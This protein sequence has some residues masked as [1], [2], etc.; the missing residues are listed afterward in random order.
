[1]KKEVF[2]NVINTLP[3]ILKNLSSYVKNRL[4]KD[5]QELLENSNGTI[6]VLI[7]LFA[8][9]AIDKYFETLENK[10][11]LQHGSLNYFKA[12]LAQVSLSLAKL[13]YDEKEMI[14]LHIK[15]IL[16]K[17]N[18]D[19]D[20]HKI[21][22]DLL[23]IFTPQYHPIIV[24]IKDEVVK[25]MKQLAL[26]NEIILAFKKDFNQNIAKQVE[27]IFGKD[28][29]KKHLTD[30]EQ[31]QLQNS[32][33]KLLL[34]MYNLKKIGFK[35]EEDLNYETTYAIWKSVG[36]LLEQNNYI[37]NYE[38]EE[39]KKIENQQKDITELIE[40]YFEKHDKHLE[41]ILFI[42]ADFGK[43]K[44]I[45][46]KQYASK[47]AK[48]YLETGEGYFPIYFNLR[49]YGR[50]SKDVTFGVIFDFIEQNYQI[51]L[52][53]DYFKTKKFFF[54][55]DSLDESGELTKS[56]ID[57]VITS[58]K[59]IQ[60]LDK[61]KCVKNRIIITTRPFDDGL[62]NQLKSH[63]PFCIENKDERKIPQYISIFGFKQEQFNHWLET[64]IKKTIN[65][66][67]SFSINLHKTI[68]QIISNEIN[69]YEEMRINS[70]LSRTELN[71][72][73]FAYMIY[74]LLLN[75]SDIK[76][77]GKIGIYLSFLNLLTKE[78][79][80]INDKTY[81]INLQEEYKYRGLLH[82]IASLWM[83]KRHSG[84]QGI[85]DKIEICRTLDGRH[86]GDADN[87]ILEKYKKESVTEIQFLSHSYFGTN[88]N[89]LHFQHQSFAEI[90]LAEYY[91]KLFIKFALDE[92]DELSQIQGRLSLGEPTTQTITFLKELL[93]LLKETTINKENIIEKRKLLFPLLASLVIDKKG[94]FYSSELY[95]EWYK[96]AS[97]EENSSIIPN[98]L[99]QN[100]PIS[101]DVLNK[102]L[103]LCT[104]I[105]E[106]N[107]NYIVGNTQMTNALYDNEV[108]TFKNGALKKLAP[109]MDKWIALLVGNAL[110]T[111]QEEKKFF[112][113]RIK[114]VNIFFELIQTW[115]YTNN[116]SAPIWAQEYF[117]GIDMQNFSDEIE[118]DRKDLDGIDF[119]FSYLKNISFS[120]SNLRGVNFSN[121]TFEEI[122][123]TNAHIENIILKNLS[124]NSPLYLYG[125]S[126]DNYVLIP[127]QIVQALMKIKNTD[128]FNIG[129]WPC[130]VTKTILGITGKHSVAF[131][132]YI[133]RRIHNTYSPIIDLLEI[134]YSHTEL[135][136]SKET[137]KSWFKYKSRTLKKDF[138]EKIDN[139]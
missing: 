117:I 13:Q 135:G 32:E 96:K 125:C 83:Y 109:D 20:T 106:S 113:A 44:S 15:D 100:W 133:L 128:N 138:E 94:L 137:M 24:Q 85:L 104:S 81:T 88:D 52:S 56:I 116:N 75:N 118:M 43:G 27:D 29:Y 21:S 35:D 31:K 11:L 131:N 130:G 71:R 6:S 10:K 80:H 48:E 50:Y 98:E 36:E 54:L 59:D 9:P 108:L 33:I 62:E 134:I 99:L 90:L 114:K 77:I 111:N 47:L 124:L 19:F 51:D 2:K 28:L 97:F 42:V 37:D 18:I 1:M 102:I 107:D 76:K 25:L 3:D 136:I 92:S 7:K 58:I 68:Q 16:E 34:D 4:D 122:F 86:T 74:Q 57:K 132:K 127:I 103:I 115:N 139:L 79:K 105:F 121:C 95:H 93:I 63:S 67:K 123:A 72:P 60:K 84:L 82:T 89:K 101:E 61:T 112:N 38:D 12:S 40:Q 64:S 73:I 45:F 5:G 87:I 78:A 129:F 39:Y 91:L 23:V 41:Q 22:S 30:I 17:F 55:I 8:G 119:S 126:L 65:S 110:E 14:S 66:H 46:L 69:V 70:S 26:S 53:N 49:D 120:E